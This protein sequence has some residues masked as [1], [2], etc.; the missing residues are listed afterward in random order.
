MTPDEMEKKIE[1]ILQMQAQFATNIGKL[2]T[3][4]ARSE[5]NIDNLRVVVADLAGVVRES[6]RLSDE[7][8]TRLDDRL[9]KLAEAQKTTDERLN[10][11][12]SVVERHITGPDH[13][14]RP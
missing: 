5:T 11:L 10:A 14:A 1:F 9:T 12:I 13:A 4:M 6:I 7:R 3:N 2:E 8:F